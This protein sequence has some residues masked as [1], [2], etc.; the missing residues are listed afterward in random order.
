M[1]H[2]K[3]PA[4]IGALQVFQGRLDR[5]A[6]RRS[7]LQLPPNLIECAIA[8]LPHD[9]GFEVQR[10]MTQ[11]Q[12][13]IDPARVPC[14]ALASGAH[15]RAR[16]GWHGSGCVLPQAGCK[17]HLRNRC[18]AGTAAAGARAWTLRQGDSIRGEQ[19]RGN[20]GTDLGSRSRACWRMFRSSGRAGDCDPCHSA[21]GSNRFS[22][23]RRNGSISAI[24][25]LDA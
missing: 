23:R 4:F 5:L 19:C 25:R 3:S 8:L 16:P 24:R 6:F 17:L 7:R 10:R 21:L 12:K 11:P 18:V 9:N 14:R 2:P 1:Q 13:P 15:H 22:R 20:I